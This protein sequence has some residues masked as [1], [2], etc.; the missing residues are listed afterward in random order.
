MMMISKKRSPQCRMCSRILKDQFNK[1]VKI[2][3]LSTHPPWKWKDGGNFLIH[4]KL[5]E[6]HS[7]TGGKK[8][9]IST[10]G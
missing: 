8:S 7:K 10:F 5:L 1:K 3:S 6:L 4:K 9:R 2:L